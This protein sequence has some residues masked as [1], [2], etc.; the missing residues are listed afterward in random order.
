MYRIISA[1]SNGILGAGGVIGVCFGASAC[2]ASPIGYQTN[3]MVYGVGG[4]RFNDYLRKG[5]VCQ[6]QLEND[7]KTENQRSK[8]GRLSKNPLIGFNKRPN[9]SLF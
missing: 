9:S 8:N 7:K 2:Y 6:K 1:L 5:K 3:L 4:Y